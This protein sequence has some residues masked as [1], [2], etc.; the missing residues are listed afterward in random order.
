MHP[1]L[2]YRVRKSRTLISVLQMNPISALLSYVF[3]N[4][5]YSV[6]LVRKRSIQTERTP[7]VGEVSANILPIDGVACSAQR[8]PTAVVSVF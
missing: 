8:I 4:K 6:V 2:L 3:T 5:K 1:K 7:H